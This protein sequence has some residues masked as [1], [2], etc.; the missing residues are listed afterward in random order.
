MSFQPLISSSYMPIPTGSFGPSA[1][2]GPFQMNLLNSNMEWIYHYNSTQTLINQVT[3]YNLDSVFFNLTE[4]AS[5]SGS[6]KK[7]CTYG[8]FRIN[9]DKNAQPNALFVLA[10]PQY[11]HNGGATDL[12]GTASFSFQLRGY[13][14]NTKMFDFQIGKISKRSTFLL[15]KNWYTL[16]SSV[17]PLQFATTSSVLA[18]DGT[19]TSLYS[20]QTRTTKS[21]NTNNA[22]KTVCLAYID[23]YVSSSGY[24]NTTSVLQ[25]CLS[26]LYAREICFMEGY[27]Q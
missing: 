21:L 13:Y 18:L 27:S 20:L 16:T 26:G 19:S 9:L 8:P 1:S 17:A 10:S 6:Y 23:C 2:L 14:E 12:Q 25:A 5:T 24:I 22:L 11:F 4:L 15:D 7:I 3:P